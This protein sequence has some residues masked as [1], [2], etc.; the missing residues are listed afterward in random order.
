MSFPIKGE[1]IEYGANVLV[2][3]GEVTEHY[4]TGRGSM[5]PG[6]AIEVACSTPGG[7]S[8]GP[9]FDKN[10]RLI[11]I[12]SNSYHDPD[13]RGPSYVSLLWTALAIEIAPGVFRPHFF[14]DKFRLLESH[15]CAIDGR[16]AIQVSMDTETGGLRMEV[17]DYS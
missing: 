8:G 11:G 12:L 6:P 9:A 17:D 16:D 5:P 13:G 2:A 4:L 7:L 1:H 14:P 10:G 15:W 3:V